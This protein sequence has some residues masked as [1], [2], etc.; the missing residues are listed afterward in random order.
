MRRIIIIGAICL[1][2]GLGGIAAFL[3]IPPEYPRFASENEA[4]NGE[5]FNKDVLL[6]KAYALSQKSYQAPPE[7]SND[8]KKLNYDQYRDI[9]FV[10]ENGPWYGQRKP[11]EIQ[12]FHPGALFHNEVMM[13][14]IVHGKS[15]PIG[16]S[17]FFFNFGKNKAL[18][19]NSAAGT[20]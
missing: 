11:F 6:Q 18:Q 10:R 1:I 8:L 2:C 15:R 4:V 14:E 7:V 19:S 17:P 12:F 20:S 9:R 3:I 13:N 16:Y 5:V